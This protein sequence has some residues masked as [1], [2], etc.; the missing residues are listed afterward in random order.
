MHCLGSELLGRDLELIHYPLHHGE[1]LISVIDGEGRCA[2]DERRLTTEQSRSDAVK[3]PDPHPGWR[4]PQRALH[5]LA[6][7]ASRLVGE[8]NGQNALW[9]DTVLFDQPGDACGKHSRLA[10]AGAREHQQRTFEVQHG[11][12]L[13]RIEPGQQ[14]VFG[15]RKRHPGSIMSNVAPRSARTL[16]RRPR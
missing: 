3:G 9:I 10:G 13:S 11:L 7:F 14:R 5:P 4:L 1:T 12:A 15:T 8:R 2:S 6:H 16:M